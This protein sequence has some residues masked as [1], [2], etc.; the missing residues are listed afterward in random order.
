MP[1]TEAHKKQA[2]SQINREDFEENSNL[3]FVGKNLKVLQDAADITDFDPGTQLLV[4]VGPVIVEL[5][6]EQIAEE[7][8][9]DGD[10]VEEASEDLTTGYISYKGDFGEDEDSLYC[11]LVFM[12]KSNGIDWEDKP[13]TMNI[14]EVEQLMDEWGIED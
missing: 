1:I 7:I 2:L 4:S 11:Y 13:A 14:E 3:F 5:A 9:E 6:L 12:P 8:D 10:V